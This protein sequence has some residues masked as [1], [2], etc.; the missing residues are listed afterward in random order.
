MSRPRQSFTSD[1]ALSEQ[2]V[3]IKTSAAN[4]PLAVRSLRHV[5][6]SFLS[7]EL[8][9]TRRGGGRLREEFQELAERLAGWK[10]LEGRASHDQ[11]DR[12]ET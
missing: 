6:K 5:W 2:L 3:F 10:A 12:S 8:W 4:V 1:C 9:E 11:T 7:D